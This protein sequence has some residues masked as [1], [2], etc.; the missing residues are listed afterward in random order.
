MTDSD[1]E[2]PLIYPPS[3]YSEL[4]VPTLN[5]TLHPSLSQLRRLLSSREPRHR[6]GFYMW[7]LVAPLTFPFTIIRESPS[8]KIVDTVT[9]P[10]LMVGL[11]VIPNIPFFFCVW[12]SWSHYRGIIH[13]ISIFEIIKTGSIV[14]SCSIQVVSIPVFPNR[15]RA[16]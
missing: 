5:P 13:P 12:R 14:I 2:I 15:S 6:R 10:S 4:S 9:Q 8:W 16:S 11:A 1:I 3:A 7:M